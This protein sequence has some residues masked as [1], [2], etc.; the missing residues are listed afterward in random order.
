L[1]PPEGNFSLQKNEPTT[2]DI[3]HVQGGMAVDLEN[4]PTAN[5]ASL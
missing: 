1:N 2:D 3:G 5:G 4:E